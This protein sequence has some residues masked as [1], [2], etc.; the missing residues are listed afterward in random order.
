[1]TIFVQMSIEFACF[2]CK[3]NLAGWGVAEGHGEKNSA[4]NLEYRIHKNIL[5]FD[6]LLKIEEASNCWGYEKM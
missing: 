5:D 6:T 1:M 3:I 2:G 4:A